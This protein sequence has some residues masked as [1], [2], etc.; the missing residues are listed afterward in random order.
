LKQGVGRAG[1]EGGASR[2]RAALVVVEVALSLML[3]VGAGLMV[4]TLWNLQHLDPGFDTEKT[5]SMHLEFSPKTY[6]TPI[7]QN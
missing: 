6:S 1:T 2:T 3:L 4:R 5:L 7:A